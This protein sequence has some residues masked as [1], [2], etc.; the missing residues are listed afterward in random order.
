MKI[1]SIKSTSKTTA[2]KA[3]GVFTA[4]ETKN[5]TQPNNTQLINNN[6]FLQTKTDNKK[7]KTP[8]VIGTIACISAI[9]FGIIKAIKKPSEIIS[10]E[11]ETVLNYAET[12]AEGLSKMI[13]KKVDPKQL[14]CVADK[15]ELLEVLP[16]LSEKNYT[17]NMQ[18]I[19]DGEFKADLHSHSNFSNGYASVKKIL[20]EAAEYGD[21]LSKK[22]NGK[23]KFYFALTDNDGVEGVKKALTIIAKNPEKYKNIRF[24][25][26]V[27]LSFAHI[28]DKSP[29]MTETSDFLAYCIDPFSK[30]LTDFLSNV[31]L[32]REKMV[33]AFISDLSKKF[34][35][36]NFSLDELTKAYNFS[37][38]KE[39]FSTNLHWKIHHYGQTKT[40][41]NTLAKAKNENAEMLYSKIMHK[42]NTGK[43]LDDLK[44]KGLISSNINENEEIVEL[45]EKY[46]PKINAKGK[47]VTSSENTID[48]IFD[49]MSKEK[50]V[51]LAFAHPLHLTER[52]DNPQKYIQ[53]TIKRSK[54][55]IQAAETYHQGYSSN[56]TKDAIF[57]ANN[58]FENL[59]LIKIGGRNNH[60]SKL[61]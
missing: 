5:N 40:A 37:L 35:D 45:R 36:T 12:L 53:D 51:I 3:N 31:R 54:G 11:Q 25:P 61:F 59:N 48:E 21:R 19:L 8:I 55:L 6:K 13:G 14:A 39:Y 60:N 24:I 27:E 46:Q 18:N 26:G 1:Q 32:K 10:T 42:T 2:F 16:K 4:F 30:G 34:P 52:L 9:T 29:N 17:Y 23:E 44:T 50:D 49:T 15:N 20:E 41:I 47:I 38:P 43:S 58:Q 7:Y 57:E 22:T 28:A 33:K 56:I